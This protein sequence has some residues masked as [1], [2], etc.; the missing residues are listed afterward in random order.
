MK[1]AMKYVLALLVGL[2]LVA[3]GN[4]EG[5][6][7]SSAA[8]ERTSSEGTNAVLLVN[9]TG[10]LSFNDSAVEGLTQAEEEYE[11]FSFTTVEYGDDNSVIE[12]YFL[13]AADSPD[14]DI[15]ILPSQFVDT[16]AEYAADYPDKQFWLF[17]TTFPYEEGEEGEYDNVYTMTY[18]SNEAAYLGGYLGASNSETNTLGFVGGIDNNIINDFLVGYIQGAQAANPDVQVISS[19]VGNFADSARGKELALAM[20][21]QD[22]TQV[23]NVAGGAGIGVLE[24]A[25]E[26]EE[27]ALGVD[28]DQA[29]QFQ[30]QGDEETASHVPT[31]VLTNIGNTLYRAVGLYRDGELP[32]GELESLG[33]AEDAVGLADNEYYQAAYSDELKT[34]IEEV[35]QQIIDGEIEVQSALDLTLDEVSQLREEAAQ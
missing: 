20:Y 5:S 33:L 17:G 23:F 9:R 32:V 19:Y 8:E 22:A 14:N 31:S 3:C 27:Y 4:Q 34:E 10:D 13:D 28:A 18:R 30:A 21:N 29:L 6:E 16:V 7:E 1:K 2:V 15:L 25:V 26:S 12:T 24:A 11:D 35:K